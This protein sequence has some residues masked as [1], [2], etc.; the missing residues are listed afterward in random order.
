MTATIL[1]INISERVGTTK[2]PV[3]EAELR[4]DHG[5]VGDAHAGDWHR[6]VSLLADESIDVMRA[7]LPGLVAGDFAENVTTRGIAVA[8]LP[9]GSRLHL[10][11]DALIEITQIGK[12]CHKGCDIRTQVG[13]CIMPREGVFGRVLRAGVI[14]PGDEITVEPAPVTG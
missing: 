9:I 4:V 12:A 13:D 14:R 8:R 11:Q 5:M 1:S 2:R 6:Q 3:P 7:S 10:G